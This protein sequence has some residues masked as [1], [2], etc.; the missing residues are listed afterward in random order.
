MED[1]KVINSDLLQEI[2]EDANLGIWTMKYDYNG[3]DNQLL[4]DEQVEKMFHMRSELTPQQ[5]YDYWFN[6]ILSEDSLNVLETLID[7]LGKEEYCNVEFLWNHPE[8][9]VQRYNLTGKVEDI[10]DDGYLVIKGHCRN[11]TE[12]I[13][14]ESAEDIAQSAQLAQQLATEKRRLWHLMKAVYV[15]E[16]KVDLLEGTIKQT[17]FEDDGTVVNLRQQ[18]FNEYVARR[19]ELIDEVFRAEVEEFLNLERLRKMADDEKGAPEE[20]LRY[21]IKK[22]GEDV[23]YEEHIIYNRDYK[24]TNVS[25]VVKDV[26]SEVSHQYQLSEAKNKLEHAVSSMIRDNMKNEKH[27]LKEVNT[28]Q[29]LVENSEKACELLLKDD[30]SPEGRELVELIMNQNKAITIKLAEIR[31]CL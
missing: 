4:P 9:G 14:S 3:V 6:R 18:D 30:L 20:T 15:A 27:V 13:K 22:D 19:K 31:D 23:I 28:V 21:K 29:S 7:M 17:I 2:L 24:D 26:T 16:A 8:Q 12:D 10:D 1:T 5:K 11:I 25:I